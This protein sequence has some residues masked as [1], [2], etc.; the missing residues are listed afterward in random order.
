[1]IEIIHE[2][3]GNLVIFNV[4]GAF[5]IQDIKDVIDA[6]YKNIKRYVIWDFT[7]S[8][9]CYDNLTVDD[10]REVS[11]LVHKMAGH[12]KTAYVAARDIDYGLLRMYEMYK[13]LEGVPVETKV[14]RKREYALKWL[15]SEE[16][17]STVL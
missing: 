8:E 4:I 14:F 13:E 2:K 16:S 9:T 17:Y 15:F 1:M 5:A 3:K 10:L 6:N 7:A 12:M 11:K